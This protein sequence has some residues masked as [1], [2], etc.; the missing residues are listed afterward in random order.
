[1]QAILYV[2]QTY[3]CLTAIIRQL[4]AIFSFQQLTVEYISEMPVTAQ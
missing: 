4:F 1:M 2:R 3:F